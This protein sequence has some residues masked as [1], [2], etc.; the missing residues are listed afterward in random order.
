MNEQP[1]MPPRPQWREALACFIAAVYFVLGMLVWSNYKDPLN[2]QASISEVNLQTL[3]GVY[4]QKPLRGKMFAVENFIR[5]TDGRRLLI[6]C[7]FSGKMPCISSNNIGRHVQI[8][9][10]SGNPPFVYKVV[11]TESGKPLLSFKQQTEYVLRV[12]DANKAMSN[13]FWTLTA[14]LAAMSILHLIISYAKSRSLH[15]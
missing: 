8:W 11:D 10:W 15:R 2:P 4:E 14:I 1:P 9:Y 6:R 12:Q 5:Q 13:L 7:G 3:A